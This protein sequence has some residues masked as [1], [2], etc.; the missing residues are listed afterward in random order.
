MSMPHLPHHQTLF[1]YIIEIMFVDDYYKDVQRCPRNRTM[2]IKNLSFDNNTNHRKAKKS[3]NFYLGNLV[4]CTGEQEINAVSRRIP[5]NPG[6]QLA[7]ILAQ[8]NNTLQAN[9][10]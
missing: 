2:S 1:E 3:L 4:T 8:L 6:E 9:S 5:N 7:Y 10:D